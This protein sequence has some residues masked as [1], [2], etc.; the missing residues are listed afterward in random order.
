MFENIRADLKT[1]DGEWGAQ[2]FWAMIIYRF[3]RWRYSIRPRFLRLPFSLIYKILFKLIY[4]DRH[5]NA[6]RGSCWTQFSD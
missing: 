5:P 1:Y 6:L 4:P 2:G 3:G